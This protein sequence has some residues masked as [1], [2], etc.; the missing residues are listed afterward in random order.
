[1]CV[2]VGVCKWKKGRVGGARLNTVSAISNLLSGDQQECDLFHVNNTKHKSI[3]HM[4]W[5]IMQERL[6]LITHGWLYAFR[7]FF[8]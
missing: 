1:M 7:S 8:V 4:L 2:R 5:H 6:L 3:Y